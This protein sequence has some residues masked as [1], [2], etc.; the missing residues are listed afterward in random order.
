M[1][2]II[3]H[4][5]TLLPAT[6]FVVTG[7]WSLNLMGLTTKRPKDL[8][9]I[10]VNPTKEAIDILERLQDSEENVAFKN[11]GYPGGNKLYRIL[12]NGIKVDFFIDTRNR[13]T[14]KID[15]GIEVSKVFDTVQAKKS[16]GRLKDILQLKMIAEMFYTTKDLDAFV[17]KEQAKLTQ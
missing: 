10:L 15:G 17:Q 2:A 3:K 12:H 7:S 8:D 9:I 16:Y 5:K 14:F 13:P 1:E 4:Y 11:Q 6:Q